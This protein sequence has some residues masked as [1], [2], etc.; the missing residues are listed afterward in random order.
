[1]AGGGF[2]A[3]SSFLMQEL[4]S[5]GYVVAA[6]EHPYG[7]VMTIFPDGQKAYNNPQALPVGAPQGEIEPA[8]IRLVDQWAGDLAYALQVFEGLNENDPQFSFTGQLDLQRV[9]VFGHSTGGGAAVEFCGREPRCIA[10][11]GLDAYLTPV[12]PAVRQSGLEQPFLFLFS[13]AWPSETNNRLLETLLAHTPN[14]ITLTLLGSD[15]YDFT[16]LPMLTPLASRLGL[17]GPLNGRRAL[18]II[19]DYTLAFFDQY[20]MGKP[21]ALLDGPNAS[22]PEIRWDAEQFAP[23]P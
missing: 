19:D 16:D 22:Y 13:Q 7:S 21:S 8:A 3:Q 4:A 10:G 14:A 15:H 6:L 11:V 12:S 2:R 17:K 9:G 5:H 20:L 18:R 1:M 23:D